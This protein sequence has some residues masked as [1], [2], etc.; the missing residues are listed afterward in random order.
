ML[1]QVILVPALAT[2]SFIEA[3]KIHFIIL[4]DIIVEILI[5][6]SLVLYYLHT[7]IISAASPGL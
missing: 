2:Y 1:S 7:R 4:A 5:V 6:G 3:N